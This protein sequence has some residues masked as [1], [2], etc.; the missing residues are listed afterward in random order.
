[1]QFRCKVDIRRV[2]AIS[3]CEEDFSFYCTEARG[4]K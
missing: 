1:M 3:A 2:P 4:D